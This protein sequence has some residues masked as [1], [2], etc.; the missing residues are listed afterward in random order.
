MPVFLDVEPQISYAWWQQLCHYKLKMDPHRWPPWKCHQEFAG[1][2]S[3]VILLSQ[4]QSFPV[5]LNNRKN[6][7][8]FFGLIIQNFSYGLLASLTV[9]WWNWLRCFGASAL[10]TEHWW[11]LQDPCL[12]S[13]SKGKTDCSRLC[14]PTVA[15]SLSICNPLMLHC[16]YLSHTAVGHLGHEISKFVT[17]ESQQTSVFLP[18]HKSIDS[19]FIYTKQS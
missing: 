14:I 5:S 1:S 10:C 9:H 7:L 2:N 4:F 15:I 16:F 8:I 18:F 6:Y 3:Q 12:I 17:L 19:E 13:L 11:Q